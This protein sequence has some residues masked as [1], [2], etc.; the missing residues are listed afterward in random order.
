MGSENWVK[1]QTVAW[2]MMH[3][4]AHR[5]LTEGSTHYHATYVAPYWQ[6]SK[7]MNLVGRIGAHIFY[8]WD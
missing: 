2:E 1:A 3:D 6:N 5:G 8:R 4:G 7:N